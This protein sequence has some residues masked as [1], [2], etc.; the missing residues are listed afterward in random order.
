MKIRI[1]SISIAGL[2]LISSPIS[3]SAG[4]TK[5]NINIV[6]DGQQE[7]YADA[8]MLQ[9]NRVLL[10]LRA[11]MSKL[12]NQND[13]E[14]M[15]WN[16]R[17]KSVTIHYGDSK[18]YVRAG[19]QQAYVNDKPL[20]LPVAPII[21]ESGKFY[22][23]AELIKQSMNKEVTWDKATKSVVISTSNKGK[24][25]EVLKSFETG[26]PAAMEKWIN[27]DKYIQHNLAFPSGREAPISAI[28]QLK[29][30]GVK[31]DVKRVF[32]DG[33]YVAVHSEVNLFGPKAVFDI[34]RFEKG[35]IVEHWDNIQDL[36][37]PNPSGH[38]MVDGTTGI[39][40][41]DKT[42]DNKALV[43]KFVEDVLMGGNIEAMPSY[44]DG[45]SY[46]QHNPMVGDGLKAVMKSFQDLAKQGVSFKY[47]KIHMVI[48]EG[49]FVLVVSEA[50]VGGNT[51]SI[52]DLFRVENGKIAEHW[53]I[54]EAIPPQDQWKNTN[55]KF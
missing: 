48:G 15:I 2:L 21:S 11:V 27:P 7:V 24:A 9:N 13:N 50:K 43:K 52:Y 55:G 44:Y 8:P 39:I 33:D 4:G 47:E 1:A 17:E 30:A 40:D 5:T 36:A 16:H 45:D 35:K 54:F 20:T 42:Q 25:V 23:P 51:A 28:G 34:F 53:D 26:D 14:H 29:G 32:Q 38:T 19:N 49:N 18:I 22:I 41:R 10:P 31:Y 12:G 6:I 46:I 37:A 3:A